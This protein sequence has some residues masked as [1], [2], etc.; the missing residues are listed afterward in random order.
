MFICI[1]YSGQCQENG[2]CWRRR[3]SEARSQEENVKRSNKERYWYTL[4]IFVPDYLC[5]IALGS[6]GPCNFQFVISQ[7]SIKQPR[8]VPLVSNAEPCQSA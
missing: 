7:P 3:V 6:E 8:V 5:T 2:G 4:A 1:Y